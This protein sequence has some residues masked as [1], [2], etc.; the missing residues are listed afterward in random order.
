MRTH[1]ALLATL[2]LLAACQPDLRPAL[3][4]LRGKIEMQHAE[5]LRLSA[6]VDSQAQVLTVCQSTVSSLTDYALNSS[7]IG[8]LREAGAQLDGVGE[9]T[10]ALSRF[11]EAVQRQAK[12]QK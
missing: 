10:A 7:T 12:E 11:N 6:F 1:S 4:D 5:I 8:W 9:C 2:P 3:D